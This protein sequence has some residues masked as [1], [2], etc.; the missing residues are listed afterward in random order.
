MPR[1]RDV[2]TDQ[3]EILFVGINP[4]LL[5]GKTGHHFAGQNEFWKLLHA[6]GLTPVVLASEEDHRLVEWQLAL[7]N[8][9]ARP[10]KIAS[11]L[12]RSELVAGK[13]ALLAKVA[14]MRPRVVALVGVTLYPVVFARDNRKQPKPE[15]PP[16]PGPKPQDLAGAHVFVLPNPSGLNASFPTFAAKLPW[17]EALRDYRDRLRLDKRQPG[18]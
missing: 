5:S 12:K 13:K 16:G 11:E 3:P 15:L 6:A 17:F 2:I 14:A 18:A 10:T 1:P 7:V 8:L 4:G 9:C